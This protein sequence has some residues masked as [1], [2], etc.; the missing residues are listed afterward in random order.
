MAAVLFS[1]M[2]LLIRLTHPNHARSFYGR[3][4]EE[5]EGRW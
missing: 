4:D 3:R 1:S 2:A 5:S